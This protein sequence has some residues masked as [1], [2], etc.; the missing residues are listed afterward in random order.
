MSGHQSFDG[1]QRRR[2]VA[3][4][5]VQ[6]VGFRPFV[7][8][9]AVEHGLTGRVKNAPEGVVME[10]QGAGPDLDA[11]LSDFRTKLPPLARV[12]R[13]DVAGVAPVEGESGFSIEASEQGAG[14]NVLISPDTATCPDCLAEMFDPDDRRYLYPFTNCTN[15]GPR[16]TITRAIPYDRPVTSMACF[17]LC[18]ACRRE[19]EDPMNRRFHAQP[20]ACPECGPKLR[21]VDKDGRDLAQGGDPLAILAS[22][23]ADGRIAAIKGLGGFHLS[24]DAGSETATALLRER[25]RRPHKPLAVMVPDLEAVRRLGD[26]GEAEQAW[27]E[28]SVR[29][30][31]LLARKAGAGLA[32]SVAPDTDRIGVMTP[33]TPLHHV[34]L[35]RFAERLPSGRPPALVMT[36]GNLSEEPIVLGNR[37]ALRRLADIAD[38]F[39][40][41]NRDILVRTDDSVLRVLPEFKTPLLFRRARGFV[42]SPVFLPKP[43]PCVLGVGPELKATLCLT[44]GDTAYVSQH[45]G[46]MENLETLEFYKEILDHLQRILRVSPVL[47]VHDLHPDY[48]TTSL[49][50]ELG[51]PTYGLQHHA[52]H[53]YA[54]LAENK[55]SGRALAL[56]LDGTGYG[57]DGTIWGGE[58]LL[59]DTDKAQHQRLARLRPFRLPG[60]EAAVREPWRTAQSLLWEAGLREPG[61]QGQGGWEW[62]WLTEFGPASRFLPQMLDKGVNAPW[63]SSCGRLFDGVSALAGLC[64]SI[65]YEGQAAIRLERAQD[66]S[67]QGSYP[68]PLDL[69]SDPAELDVRELVFAVARDLKNGATPGTVS[70]R[71]HRGLVRGLAEAAAVLA[72]RSGTTHVALSGGVLQ[73]ATVAVELA[74]TLADRG[75]TPFV[76]GQSPP[77]DGCI[78]LGQAAY[79]QAM[80]RNLG[81]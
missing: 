72:K 54:A 11:F 74:K 18:D 59:I 7:Y 8:R 32:A 80:A 31:V 9:L 62:P 75:L 61:L 2:A 49:A 55:F 81:L 1:V 40:L 79:G 36:S 12:V 15:C 71:F 56:A 16:Y 26:V 47:A 37:E 29:P 33:Y 52:A 38:V 65:S 43:G 77:N 6:G 78:S 58:I 21:L 57:E 60:G 19:Y 51:L 45:I 68:L 69:A 64:S 5:Q 13:L 23:L 27:L 53:S 46:D 44:K 48:M 4:G 20:N 28:G 34:L 17:P 73:N 76:H 24:C 63:T 35:R 30:I 25:K 3:E 50:K 39:L 42:P 66:F 67:A 70:R 10:L 22:M 14:H 41:H